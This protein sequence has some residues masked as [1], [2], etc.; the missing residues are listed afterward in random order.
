MATLASLSGL[1]T[2]K[3][4][5]SELEKLQDPDYRNQVTQQ[6]KTLISQGKKV[7][8]IPTFSDTILDYYLYMSRNIASGKATPQ[9]T[10]SLCAT[11]ATII[12]E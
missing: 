8:L 11:I 9:K 12:R 6:V 1:K 2:L 4:D 3:S 10:G 7:L 5:I